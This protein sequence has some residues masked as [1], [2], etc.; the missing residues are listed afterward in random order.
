LEGEEC[1][2]NR[3]QEKAII[4][5]LSKGGQEGSISR[6]KPSDA[7]PPNR[8]LHAGEKKPGPLDTLREILPPE[9]SVKALMWKRPHAL[10]PTHHK[11]SASQVSR[12]KIA[13]KKKPTPSPLVT[14]NI[15]PP[16]KEE[17]TSI[18]PRKKE[19]RRNGC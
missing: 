11:F 16:K 18:R 7:S 4:W 13:E 14:F 19:K 8:P 3:V 9:L 15:N 6:T 2:K 5:V 10:M 12:G 1:A 17:S